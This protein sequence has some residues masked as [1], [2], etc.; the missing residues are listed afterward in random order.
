MNRQTLADMMESIPEYLIT[1]TQLGT[2][3][4]KICDV[5]VIVCEDV[6]GIHFGVKFR[7]TRV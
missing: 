6:K 2:L 3:E 7:N 4:A 5:P 1:L